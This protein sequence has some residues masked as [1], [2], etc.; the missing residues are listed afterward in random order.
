[1]PSVKGEVFECRKEKIDFF[2]ISR[3]EQS[4]DNIAEIVKVEPAG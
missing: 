3:S 2:Q 4:V 1:M